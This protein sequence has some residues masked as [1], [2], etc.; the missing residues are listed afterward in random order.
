M[1]FTSSVKY[2]ISKRHDGFPACRP[3]GVI[4]SHTKLAS[5]DGVSSGCDQRLVGTEVPF[6][7]WRPT[8]H[9]LTGASNEPEVS[10]A[11]M[12]PQEI[13]EEGLTLS[14]IVTMQLWKSGKR[15]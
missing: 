7:E 11:A 12:L 5:F 3:P 13:S 4:I 15:H 2:G 8:T 14:G 1:G 9:G 10:I 6:R